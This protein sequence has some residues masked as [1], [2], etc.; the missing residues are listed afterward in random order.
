VY[1]NLES[2][3]KKRQINTT[4]YERKKSFSSIHMISK[5]EKCH[6]KE[7]YMF[8]RITPKQVKKETKKR[9]TPNLPIST[10]VLFNKNRKYTQ[11]YFQSKFIACLK[12][13]NYS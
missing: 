3:K 9:K 1:F 8:L 5:K 11:Y 7:N 13:P 12:Q 2:F 10:E 4:V 6:Q